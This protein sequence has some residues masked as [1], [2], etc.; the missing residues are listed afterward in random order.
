MLYFPANSNGSLNRICFLGETFTSTQF[1]L[2][3]IA[4]LASPHAKVDSSITLDIFDWRLNV[5]FSQHSEKRWQIVSQLD[6]ISSEKSRSMIINT[7]TSDTGAGMSVICCFKAR[8]PWRGCVVIRLSSKQPEA[9]NSSAATWPITASPWSWHCQH[10]PV[11]NFHSHK[12]LLLC[13]MP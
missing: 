1:H 6:V 10:S 3:T 11:P 2:W 4:F 9:F 7:N 12:S 5:F 13:Y 8:Q